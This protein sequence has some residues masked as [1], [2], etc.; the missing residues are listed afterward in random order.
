MIYQFWVVFVIQVFFLGFV[1]ILLGVILL[2]A[3]ENK[4]KFQAEDKGIIGI[5]MKRPILVESAI[6]APLALG[7][8]CIS[9]LGLSFYPEESVYGLALLLL[10]FFALPPM[11]YT[12][13]R[14]LSVFRDIIVGNSEFTAYDTMETIEPKK[15]AWLN[16]FAW[17]LSLTLLV[18][19]FVLQ[20]LSGLEVVGQVLL[21]YGISG[22][23]LFTTPMLL[24][25][26]KIVRREA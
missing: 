13:H 22:L 18:A 21:I 9:S 20:E 14:R 26:P 19:Y 23:V 15:M 25:L 1:L 5:L 12:I 7:I 10:P 2:M 24:S 3:V 4:V 17:S 6:Q 11:I 8:I 16:L